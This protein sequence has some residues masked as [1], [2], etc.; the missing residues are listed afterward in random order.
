MPD[1]A[2][3]V[4][5]TVFARQHVRV[6]HTRHGNVLVALAASV[7]GV[8]N[9]HEACREFVAEIALQNSLFNEHSFLGGLAFVVHI[10]RAAPPGHGAVV[11][12]GAFLAGNPL[13]YQSC[14][15]GGFLAIEVRFQSVADRFM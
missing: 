15:R 12:D 13:A 14:E 9:P 1:R 5:W 7:A 10:E 4:L 8:G 6:R 3:D 11:D 2:D